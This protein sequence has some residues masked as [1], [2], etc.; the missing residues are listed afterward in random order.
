MS[1]QPPPS[2]VNGYRLFMCIDTTNN[3]TVYLASKPPN[4]KKIILKFI[5][6]S[7]KTPID[8]IE[9]ECRIQYDMQHPF[10]MPLD[11]C[12]DFKDYR[13]LVMPRANGGP[14]S[15]LSISQLR[16]ACMIIFRLLQGVNFMHKCHVLHGDIKPHNVVLMEQNNE[17]PQPR[18]IDFGHATYLENPNCFCRCHLLTCTYSPPEVLSGKPHSFPS[19]I[20][21][22]GATF[23]YLVT[24]KP[25][26]RCRNLELMY[27]DAV[28]LE[29]CFDEHLGP[30]FPNSGVQM[31]K[32]MMNPDPSK[33]PTAEQC[34]QCE[35]FLQVLGIE[36]IQNEIIN[37]NGS[38]GSNISD[39]LLESEEY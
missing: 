22:L 30:S 36:W 7:G 32:A 15:K 12:F 4:P 5:P 11:E 31:I 35:L 38:A 13:V 37:I 8:R 3:S 23:Y 14:L 34:L 2:R 17:D 26:L 21:S 27:N 20:W 25:V 24:K 18:I 6:L 29:L 19:D 16:P 1:I 9:A 39:A 33:R 28:N 10:L